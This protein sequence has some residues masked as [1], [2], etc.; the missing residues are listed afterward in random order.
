MMFLTKFG[1]ALGMLGLIAPKA[2]A[3]DFYTIRLPSV[4]VV[5]AID[6]KVYV[7][8]L[9]SAADAM[10]CRRLPPAKGV[11]RSIKVATTGRW[12]GACLGVKDETGEVILTQSGQ[13][14][15]SWILEQVDGDT[16]KLKAASGKHDGLYLRV[17][18]KGEER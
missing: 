16:F 11:T 3:V 5:A 18:D 9:G 1:I 10:D 14:T 13:G 8:S 12:A 15:D 7:V 17:G 6:G 4:G 2:L